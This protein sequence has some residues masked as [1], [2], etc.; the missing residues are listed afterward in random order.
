[1]ITADDMLDLLDGTVKDLKSYL[2]GH[3]IDLDHLVYMLEAER[4]VNDR[5]TARESLRSEI[6]SRKKELTEDLLEQDVEEL[7]AR[8]EDLHADIGDIGVDLS[9]PS[10]ARE[11]DQGADERTE[12]L[13]D[14]DR[15]GADISELEDT[16]LSELK[17]M[18]DDL[19]DTEDLRQEIADEYAVTLD[20]LEGMDEEDLRELRET[21]EEKRDIIDEIIDDVDKTAEELERMSTDDLKKIHG[22]I[23]AEEEIDEEEIESTVEEDVAG[24][25]LEED[26]L[27]EVNAIDLK[28]QFGPQASEEEAEEPEGYVGRITAALPFLGQRGGGTMEEGLKEAALDN[29]DR[30]RDLDDYRRAT[31][32]VS[33]AL[34][35]FLEIKMGTDRE[36]TYLEV[37]DRLAKS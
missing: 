4:I 6:R 3:E 21:Y 2:R 34:K 30:A 35:Q 25:E 17:E 31:L 26:A 12:V 7:E 18:R 13:A 33:H 29:L 24:E 36:L 32:V 19:Q 9:G 8:V 27:A 23:L 28:K 20:E 11:A 14:L 5:K 37:P 22:E 16:D 1:M 15:L 10:I